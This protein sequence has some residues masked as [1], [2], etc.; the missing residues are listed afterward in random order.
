MEHPSYSMGKRY[1]D[2]MKTMWF[3]FFYSSVIPIG[4]I[5]SL[6]GLICYYFT[7]KYNLLFRRTVKE[8]IGPQ[9]SFKMVDLVD[10]SLIFHT[11][12]E[13]FFKYNTSHYFDVA[14]F[15]LLFCVFVLV[16]FV[17]LQKVNEYIFEIETKNDDKKYSEV[18]LTFDTDYDRENPITKK[19][20]IQKFQ[21]MRNKIND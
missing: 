4:T 19:E 9:L 10:Y 16:V 11:F 7:D 6:A 8:S 13:V 21:E 14:N 18:E 3:T 1:A 17:P 20:S 2:I 12:G 15:V 5:I